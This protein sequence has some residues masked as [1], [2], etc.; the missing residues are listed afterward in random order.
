MSKKKKSKTFDP[1]RLELTKEEILE[2]CD[3]V[4]EKWRTKTNEN[5]QHILAMNAV[6]MSVLFTDE[7]SLKAIWDEILR[8]AF[9]LLYKNAIALAKEENVDWSRIMGKI[10]RFEEV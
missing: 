6:R 8:W 2:F 9:V 7:D 4:L 3:R 10:K 1:D 5:A